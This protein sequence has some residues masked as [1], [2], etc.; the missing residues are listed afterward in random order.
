M[1]NKSFLLT[2]VL[3]V[4]FFASFVIIFS[5]VGKKNTIA[6]PTNTIIS[7]I[8]TSTWKIYKSEKYGILFK[9]PNHYQVKEVNDVTNPSYTN[10]IVVYDTKNKVLEMGGNKLV[11]PNIIVIR[12][13]NDL[14]KV[15]DEYCTRRNVI[16]LGVNEFLPF[17]EGLGG[18]NY[19]S[20]GYIITS[21]YNEVNEKDPVFSEILSSFKFIE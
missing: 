8:D 3:S 21:L 11:S 2:L 19:Y 6:L 15:C 7:V 13:E 10:S 14:N 1:K 20:N 5:Q 16:K 4:I 18:H 12:P 9:Y 17:E